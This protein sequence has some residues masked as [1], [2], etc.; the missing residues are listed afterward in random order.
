MLLVTG[1]SGLLGSAVLVEAYDLGLSVSGQYW[2]HPLNIPDITTYKVNLTDGDAARRLLRLIQPDAV[3]HC[4]AATNIDWCEDHPQEADK[5]N[6]QVPATLADAAR[7]EGARFLHIS[8]DAVFDGNTGNYLESNAT[9]PLNEYAKSKLRGEQEV[10]RLNSESLILRVN[11]YGWNAQN[12]C[13]LAEWILGELS[14][15]RQVPG[16]TD[17]WFCPMLVNDLAKV[18]FATM[19]RG[20]R[21][22]YHVVGSERI[23]KY[24][25]ARKVAEMFEFDSRRVVPSQ[26]TEAHLRA[27]RSPDMSL[28]TDKIVRALGRQMPNV[29]SGLLRFRHLRDDGYP[30]RVKSYVTGVQG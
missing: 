14:S 30:Q 11:I 12:K 3:I 20:L 10:M 18:I 28:N 29:D 21:G 2:Q 24:D 7:A 15:G 9:R 6:A 22:I 17:V 5:L 26:L 13:S 4:A 23:S 16:F 19:Q 1:A 8:T 27:R 25:F